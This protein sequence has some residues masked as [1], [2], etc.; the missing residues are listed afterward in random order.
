M[1][2][3]PCDNDAN[4]VSLALVQESLFD[5]SSIE[6]ILATAD[7]ITIASN[8]IHFLGGKC[9]MKICTVKILPRSCGCLQIGKELG[10]EK[11]PGHP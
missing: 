7:D 3:I 1:A 8:K 6:T 2:R 9:I 11:T 10:V 4:C 5:V